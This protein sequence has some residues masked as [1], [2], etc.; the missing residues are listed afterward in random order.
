ML[1]NISASKIVSILTICSNSQRRS[2]GL[3][4]YQEYGMNAR[5][6]S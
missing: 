3:S 5:K 6:I 1:S 2:M 4:K